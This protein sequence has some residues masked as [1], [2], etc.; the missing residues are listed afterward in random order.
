MTTTEYRV[1]H[2]LDD[3]QEE[4]CSTDGLGK[5][6]MTRAVRISLGVLRAYLIAM[7]LML[8]YHVLDLSGLLHRAH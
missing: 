7:T 8:G 4:K 5:I 6:R 1:V 3:V 2:P